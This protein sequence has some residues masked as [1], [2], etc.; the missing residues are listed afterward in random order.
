L[1]AGRRACAPSAPRPSKPVELLGAQLDAVAIFLQRSPTFDHSSLRRLDI[2]TGFAGLEGYLHLSYRPNTGRVTGR[3]EFRDRRVNCAK[4]LPRFDGYVCLPGRHR[5]MC[6][7]YPYHQPK[8]KSRLHSRARKL[9][10]RYHGQR[11]APPARRSRWKRPRES[12]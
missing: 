12:R 7:A 2:N 3:I 5:S 9:R 4:S 1:V 6:G 11:P 10:R 8:C